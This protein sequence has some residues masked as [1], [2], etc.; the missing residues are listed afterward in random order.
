MIDVV[1]RDSVY[2]KSNNIIINSGGQQRKKK[3]ERFCLEEGSQLPEG[4]SVCSSTCCP[5]GKNFGLIIGEVEFTQHS[6]VHTCYRFF[7][8]YE[9]DK[10]ASGLTKEPLLSVPQNGTLSE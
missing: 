2:G 1:F 10:K 8:G 9:S 4:K 7:H 5:Q 6:K 3:S